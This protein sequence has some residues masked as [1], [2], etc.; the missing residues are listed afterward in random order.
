MVYVFMWLLPGN[1]RWQHKGFRQL[2]GIDANIRP[3]HASC[4]EL[5]LAT[6]LVTSL[7]F[8]FELIKFSAEHK[9]LGLQI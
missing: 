7:A 6:A 2:K 1:H 8:H 4:Y 9:Q 3:L 5:L